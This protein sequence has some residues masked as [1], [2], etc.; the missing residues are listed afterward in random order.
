MSAA[1]SNDDIPAHAPAPSAQGIAGDAA[2]P[3]A[4]SRLSKSLAGVRS[5]KSQRKTLELLK[6]SL[7]A[8]R[9]NDFDRATRKALDA[10]KVDETNGLA[11][12]V[13]AICQE[14]QNRFS[15]AINAYEAALQLL[16]TTPTSP[17]TWADWRSGWAI[18]RSP[19]SC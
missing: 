5:V 8:I 11:W 13:L 2:S 16:P 18:W 17:T 15:A 14:K 1:A 19:K 4:I 10:L 6:Q 9:L 7:G 12:H 3:A